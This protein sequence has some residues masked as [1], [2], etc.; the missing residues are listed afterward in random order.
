MLMKWP[1]VRSRHGLDPPK[2]ATAFL[3]MTCEWPASRYAAATRVRSLIPKK[4]VFFTPLR[5]S[6]NRI[7][8]PPALKISAPH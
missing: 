2:V 7:F 8:T 1:G 3:S 5:W 6:R 4:Y